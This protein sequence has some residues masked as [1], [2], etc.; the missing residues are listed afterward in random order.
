MLDQKIKT[1]KKYQSTQSQWSL[2]SL[3]NALVRGGM[4]AINFIQHRL[5]FID[6]RVFLRRKRFFK[7]NSLWFTDQMGVKFSSLE[8]REERGLFKNKE[9]GYRDNLWDI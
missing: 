1:E 8:R 9:R 4:G 5:L 6:S 2:I 7:N 3:K